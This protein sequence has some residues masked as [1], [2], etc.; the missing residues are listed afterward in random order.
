MADKKRSWK[1]V[2]HPAKGQAQ[3][4]DVMPIA[5]LRRHKYGGAC[6]CGLRTNSDGRIPVFIHE[7]ADGRELVER[8]G[9]Q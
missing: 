2:T 6:W 9:V 8:D 1:T 7:S 4:V 5:D 3:Y